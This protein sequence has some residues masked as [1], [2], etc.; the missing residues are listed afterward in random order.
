MVTE[1]SKFK[2]TP[3][4]A[5]RKLTCQ[6]KTD[7]FV[8]KKASVNHSIKTCKRCLSDCFAV[9][10][11]CLSGVP[12]ERTDHSV[13]DDERHYAGASVTLTKIT[14]CKMFPLTRVSCRVTGGY[15]QY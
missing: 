6:K 8:S 10:Q 5:I 15:G 3:V 1:E 12:L 4:A 7:L 11:G 13:V 9:P 14:S 2:T